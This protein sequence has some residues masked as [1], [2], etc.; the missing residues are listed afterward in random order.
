[1][2]V[3]VVVLVADAGGAVVVL[4]RV[5][6]NE[7]AR[8]VDVAEPVVAEVQPAANTRANTESA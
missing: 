3:V 8:L 2:P 5:E 6:A 7:W 1:M 4:A